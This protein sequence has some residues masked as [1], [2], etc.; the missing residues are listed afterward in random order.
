[1]ESFSNSGTQDSAEA[2]EDPGS[3]KRSLE[4]KHK[5]QSSQMANAAS[6]SE[7]TQSTTFLQ[8]LGG[9]FRSQTPVNG[10]PVAS[11]SSTSSATSSS[12]PEKN[13]AFREALEELLKEHA[14]D[15]EATIVPAE[16]QRLLHNILRFSEM[17]VADIMIPRTDI[18]AIDGASSLDQIKD[19]YSEHQHSRMPV[20]KESLDQIEGFLHIKDLAIQIFTGKRLDISAL[21]RQT[22]FVPP[23]MKLLDLLLKMRLSSVHIA[24]VVD[25]YGGTDGLVT[26]EDIV[27]EIVGEIHDEHDDEDEDEEYI[28]LDDDTLEADARLEIEQLDNC[29]KR[30]ISVRG[31]DEDFDTIGGLIFNF[32][33][34]VPSAGETFD[35]PTGMKITILEADPR[36]VK[37]VRVQRIELP[38]METATQSA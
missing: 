10:Y 5:T 2:E 11:A 20:Y 23:S 15:A 19:I 34:R 18:V 1:M 37:R 8:F 28:W 6:H 26:M 30:Q 35:Y 36:S 17:N 29:F 24:I 13:Q 27:E 31:E 25:E 33:G 16:E 9:L 21:M 32:L 14:G 38:E 3:R 7:G 22:L 12:S 4:T